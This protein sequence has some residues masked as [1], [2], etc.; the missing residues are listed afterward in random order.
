M[1]YTL[2]KQI[3]FWPIFSMIIQM[4]I[5]NQLVRYLNDD[6]VEYLTN[7]QSYFTLPL[8]AY[9]I[10]CVVKLIFMKNWPQRHYPAA[11]L[12]L[13]L[14]FT[15]NTKMEDMLKPYRYFLSTLDNCMISGVGTYEPNNI[16]FDYADRFQCFLC[17]KLCYEYNH[18]IYDKFLRIF[19]KNKH[20]Y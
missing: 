19:V 1:C 4:H 7:I 15:D 12:K 13:G 10:G 5:S 9:V 18:F 14:D 3:P 17:N 8:Q 6:C 2:N 11:I 20:S 16:K